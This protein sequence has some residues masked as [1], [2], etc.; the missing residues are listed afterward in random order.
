[1]REKTTVKPPETA[2]FCLHCLKNPSILLD[3]T[4]AEHIT[5][6]V[7]ERLLAKLR[8]KGHSHSLNMVDRHVEHVYMH[9]RESN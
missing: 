2:Q 5:Q 8:E 3:Y 6:S 7:Y 9:T 1:M 4:L